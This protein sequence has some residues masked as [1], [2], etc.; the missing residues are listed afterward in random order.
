MKLAYNITEAAAEVGLSER[1]LKDAIRE[2][3]LHA[4]YYNTKPL[5]S[6]ADLEAWYESLPSESSR[7]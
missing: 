2:N 6:H 4:K 5:V 1:A 3:K 7:A